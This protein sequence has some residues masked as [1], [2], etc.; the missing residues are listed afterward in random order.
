MSLI[1]SLLSEKPFIIS[2]SDWIGW[3]GLLLW[4]GVITAFLWRWRG[5]NKK[6][7]QT[8]WIILIGLLVITPLTSLVIGIRLPAWNTFPP[9]GVP[10]EPVGRALML[11]SAIPWLL[12]AGLLGPISA[13]GVAVLSGTLLAFWDTHSIFTPFEMAF[14]AILFSA[15]VSQQYRTRTYAA[16]RVPL[17]AALAIALIYPLIFVPGVIFIT[18]G[19]LAARIDYAVMQAAAA[20]LVVGG[21]LLVAGIVALFVRVLKPGSWGGQ[22][23]WIPSPAESKLEARLIF[24]MAPLALVLILTLMIANWIVAGDAALQMLEERMANASSLAAQEVPFFLDAG[25]NL[26]LQFARD[27]RLT[28]E[29]L[30]S[31]ELNLVL[32]QLLHSTPYF[33]QLFLL[34]EMGQPLDRKSVV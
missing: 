7:T 24:S 26:I 10:L 29:E 32:E 14:L 11:F 25:Q 19:P 12:A 34:D 4:M 22:P 15:A 2:P 21:E 23:P 6:F 17:I 16:L 33:R 8:H 5:Y 20:A 30:S 27:E 31:D 9:P 13:A 18:Q 28:D 1:T 3:L